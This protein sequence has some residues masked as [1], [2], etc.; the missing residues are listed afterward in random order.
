M[1]LVP[2]NGKVAV[3]GAGISGLCYSYFLRK[4]RPD[5][6]VLIFE[7]AL[8]PGGWIKTLQ[9]Q[10]KQDVVRLEKGP[11]TL[12]G[13]S[14]GTLLIVD[15]MR[16]LQL[17][18]EVEVMKAS[19]NANR[20]WL[21]DG[22]NKLVQVPNS[23]PLFL[24]FLASDVTDGAVTGTITEPFRKPSKEGG[25]ES[26]ES[27]ILRRFGSPQMANNI[28]SAIMHGIY[29]GDVAKLSVNTTLPALAELEKTHGLVVKAGLSKMFGKKVPKVLNPVLRE[30]E[31]WVSPGANLEQMSADLKKFPILRLRSGLQTFPKAL[32]EYLSHDTGVTLHFNTKVTAVDLKNCA[33]DHTGDGSRAQFDHIRFNAGFKTLQSITNVADET[34]MKGFQDVEYSTI[35]LANIYT[36]LKKL[37]PKELEGF[38]F[39]VPKKNKNPEGLLGVIYD[40]CTET[41][42]QN[43][44]DESS[45]PAESY[46]KLTLMMGGH[47]YNERGIPSTSGSLRA[48]KSVLENILGFDTSKFNIILRDEANTEDK[49]ISLNDDDLLISYNLHRDC[50]P[51]YNVG[52]S[53]NVSSV[54][55]WV[56]MESHGKVTLGGPNM[57]KLGI[58]DCVVNEFEAAFRAK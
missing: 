54:V 7:S 28:I 32:A 29:S 17:E 25:D 21:L 12:R 44:F 1:S 36:K 3:V 51:L 35:F 23:I 6:H 34:A 47:F 41:D 42:G 57:G 53:E 13:V 8:E 11:R 38:G 10:D 19:S 48:A 5:V 33:L 16:Q 4:L 20:K 9:L 49:T 31:E 14:D 22:S 45:K 24:K 2:K 55:N 43:F 50:I 56:G 26:I 58:P 37:I 15:I 39:L 27:F 18:N 52:F 46:T 30:Y 40:S